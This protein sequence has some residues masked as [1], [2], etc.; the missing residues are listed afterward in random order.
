VNEPSG[1]GAEADANPARLLARSVAPPARQSGA[2]LS[3]ETRQAKSGKLAQRQ[4][5]PSEP[6]LNVPNWSGLEARFAAEGPTVDLIESAA[7]LGGPRA[8]HWFGRWYSLLDARG[9]ATI[10]AL[11]RLPGP[12]ALELLLAAHRLGASLP[13]RSAKTYRN[14][15]RTALLA[16]SV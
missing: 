7:E 5:F 2:R 9:E 1:I 14:R 15:V 8:I 13:R 12:E 11:G 16:R 10:A 3:V 4:P 6:E